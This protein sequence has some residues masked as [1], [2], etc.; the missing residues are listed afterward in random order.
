M[1]VLTLD[2][3]LHD[4]DAW[5]YY[6]SATDNRRCPGVGHEQTATSGTFKIVVSSAAKAPDPAGVQQD[7]R[8]RLLAILRTPGDAAREHRGL[9]ADGWRRLAEVSAAGAKIAAGQRKIRG[10]LAELVEK[11]PWTAGLATV[12]AVLA[13]LAANEAALAIEQAD[14]VA[15]LKAMDRRARTPVRPLPARRTAS[16]ASSS[17][18]W[19]SCRRSRPPAAA[20]AKR[21]ATCRPRSRE[22]LQKLADNLE[23]FI[24][25]QRKVI[26]AAPDLA[27]KPVDAFTPE[28][29]RLLDDLQAV[30]DKWEKF[31]NEAFA[32]FSK[33]AQQDFS[34]PVMLKELISVKTDVTMAKDALSAR[35][36]TEIATALE[37]NGIENAKT[38]DRQHRE[39]AA[40]RARPHEVGHG[41]PRRRSSRSSRPSCPR[42]WRTWSATCWSRRRTSSRRWRT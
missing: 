11:F 35:R 13:D 27:K 40:G 9:P 8:E 16:S 2:R 17:R 3:S 28:D 29:E 33:L 30:Q 32:D 6:A 38:P 18:C 7:L 23:E 4:G 24:A 14:V 5:V 20:P 41:R 39:V 1:H 15:A 21:A 12:K 22:K 31:L 26:A 25:A 19:P 34:N 37:D 10:E 42:S 36:P